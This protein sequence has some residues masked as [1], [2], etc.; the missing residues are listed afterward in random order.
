MDAQAVQKGVESRSGSTDAERETQPLL[1]LLDG[2]EARHSLADA[3]PDK[4]PELE[5]DLDD[6]EAQVRAELAR[7][8]E[9]FASR[10][11]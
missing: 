10:H 8:G 4:H 1:R 5:A 9:R 11:A 6:L 3:G 7:R 2:C